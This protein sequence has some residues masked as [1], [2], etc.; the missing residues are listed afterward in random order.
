M[1]RK[2]IRTE[3]VLGRHRRQFIEHCQDAILAGRE[4]A[5]IYLVA[6]RPLLDHIVTQIIDGRRVHGCRALPVFLFDGLVRHVLALAHAEM[7]LIDEGAKYFLI[8]QV[9]GRLAE[10]QALAHL[11]DIALLP[12]CVDS[13][14]EIIGELKRAGQRPDEF[15]QFIETAQ[16]VD[17]R[18]QDVAGIYEAYQD[19]LGRRRLMD[20]DDAYVM[21]RDMLAGEPGLPAWLEHVRTLFIDGFFDFTPIQKQL[22][23]YLAIRVPEVI[24]NLSFDE[25][26]PNVFEPLNDTLQFF[27]GIG[28]EKVRQP[29]ETEPH[30]AE[31]GPLRTNLFNP[32]AS[33]S[34]AT[35]PIT[36]QSAPDVLQEVRQA[37][38]E[39]KRLALEEDIQPA[40][41]AVI[42]RDPSGYIETIRR[43]FA[44]E[45]IP[46]ALDVREIITTIP[47]VKA[48]LKVLE[49]RCGWLLIDS[50][51]A[52]LKND[53]LESF[54]PID[55]DAADNA[56]LAVGVQLTT[57]QWLERAKGMLKLKQREVERV[58]ERAVDPEEIELEVAR[59]Q[60]GI[61]QLDSAIQAVTR[62]R[63]VLLEI[64]EQATVSEF[65]SAF[66]KALEAF[67][68]WERLQEQLRSAASDERDLQV[69][70]RD[71]RGLEKMRQVL[72]QVEHI[73]RDP[74]V[75]TEK[76]NA[77]T[78]KNL[79]DHLLG[80]TLLRTQRGDPGGVD[81][82]E[83][84]QARALPFRAAFVV[85]LIEGRF[86]QG[87]PRDWLYPYN[88]RNE[89]AEAGLFLEDLS[90]AGFQKKEEHFFYQT[91]CQATERLYLSYPR[92]VGEHEETIPSS[93]IEEVRQVYRVDDESTISIKHLVAGM[94]DLQ[95]VSSALELGQTVL[96]RLWQKPGE[97]EPLLLGLYNYALGA[98]ILTP[99]VFA[100]LDIEAQRDSAMFGPFDGVLT[101]P[102]IQRQLRQRFGRERVY[103]ASQFNTYGACPFQFF[104]QR[105]LRLDPREE[106]SLDL[107]ALDRG[108]L[109][110]EILYE[111]LR[112]HTDES[113]I[114][115]RLEEYQQEL[116]SL[117][118]EILTK[119]EHTALP[120]NRALWELQKAELVDI[121]LNFLDAEVEYQDQVAGRGVQPHWLEL[122]FGM[123]DPETSHPDSRA[124]YLTL[125]R[126]D[127]A[128]QVRGR[129]D[130]VD[131]SHD[132]QHIAYD[133]KSSQGFRRT[134]MEEGRDLQ[135]PLY[136]RALGEIF[137]SEG[138]AVIG[139]GYYSIKDGKRTN[140]LYRADRQAYTGIGGRAGANVDPQHF[141]AVLRQAERYAWQ[142]VAGMRRG[143]F[144]V[145]PKEQAC[146]PRCNYST[147]C[148]FDKD[149]I[150]R[151]VNES[152]D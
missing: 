19:V 6:T 39:I 119:Y 123:T 50:F 150:R 10:E 143:D 137:L 55:R 125:R 9:M 30:H 46:C 105:I 13:I 3:P 140:G 31:L 99:S 121:V 77:V 149:R 112:R 38:K 16:Q 42:V 81:V 36:V 87:V 40:S 84:T 89:L 53:Y 56:M 151:K 69:V 132:G 82:L 68:L 110:H 32:D 75:D 57:H 24:V 107:V 1:G 93:F 49:G 133:Y 88:E 85:G 47:S 61:A 92:V 71:L 7:T 98:G 18:D 145:A 130:R 70:A 126:G 117:A 120:L 97:D 43:V 103:S 5:F 4:D 90:P 72:D 79:L 148:R 102:A 115:E 73:A 106:A 141:E 131:R 29:P 122:G 52:L 146:C 45:G 64:P 12:G 96:A 20:P 129:I 35:P 23:H 108:R 113:L 8:E 76:I 91:V 80:R 144:R 34:P 15:R 44:D 134:E 22:V 86:P 114:R 66:K 59:L 101:D 65:V 138:E 21:V 27:E 58:R 100:R 127:D 60:R 142:Y 51:V 83:V 111:F 94:S 78:F 26:N 124:E 25:R 67:R 128:I 41:M 95:C 116:R 11:T 74:K 136:I 37:A 152:M 54:C 104:C 147:V 63:T 109:L 139:G 2:E 14:G 135:I 33:P 62:M 17:E 118:T 48:A 28:L